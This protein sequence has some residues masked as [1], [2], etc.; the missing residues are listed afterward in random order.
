MPLPVSVQRQRLHTRRIECHGYRRNDGLWDIEGYLLVFELGVSLR[1][2]RISSDRIKRLVES[3]KSY[4]RP[5]SDAVETVDLREG[6]HDTLVVLNY[7]LKHYNK[8]LK[9]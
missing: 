5:D 9:I 8:L 2:I 4:G 6:L 1:T 7:H 3:L